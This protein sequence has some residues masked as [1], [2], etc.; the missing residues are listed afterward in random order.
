MAGNMMI[1]SMHHSAYDDTHLDK[2]E[3]SAFQ[4]IIFLFFIFVANHQQ[5]LMMMEII[6]WRKLI[7]L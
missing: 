7:K 5:W 2:T 4:N 3:Q 1:Q 6:K